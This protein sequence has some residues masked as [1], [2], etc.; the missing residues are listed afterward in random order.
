MQTIRLSELKSQQR[1]VPLQIR[2]DG[3]E[4]TADIDLKD[5][6][7]P[8]IEVHSCYKVTKYIVVD[9][10]SY[11]P[12]LKHQASL[13]IGKKTYFEPFS[14]K[15]IPYHFFQ[16]ASY[17]DLDE[18]MKPPKQLTDF[19][20]VVEKNFETTTTTGKALRKVDIR[21]ENNKPVQ[22]TL[23]PAK[24]H[25]IGGDVKRGDIIAISS[26][27]ATQFRD[28]KQLESTYATDVFINPTFDDIQQ[29]IS[30]LKGINID[31]L[32]SITQYFVTIQD[33]LNLP[34][35]HDKIKEIQ[36]Y[37]TWFN[38]KCS[39]CNQQVYK[40]IQDTAYYV[41]SHHENIQPKFM[42]C[43]NATIVD[44]SAMTDAVFFNE[45]MADMLAT[46][47]QDMVTLQG[48]DDPKKNHRHKCYQK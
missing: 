16:F 14:D 11:N 21:D 40:E 41:C 39:E 13:K 36:A 37:R 9:N 24:R 44:D 7:E 46:S 48:Y 47:C 19:I 12:T 25:L 2:G 32:E 26:A 35:T 1:H 17:D 27:Q 10:K 31:I 8:D 22:L 30:R 6:Y 42:Y 3:I 29:H 33:I 43:V 34:F 20:G 28:L 15:D 5:D 18:R 4:A 45:V 23:W 38:V